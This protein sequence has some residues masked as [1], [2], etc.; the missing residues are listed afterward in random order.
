MKCNPVCA[1]LLVALL[2]SGGPALAQRAVVPLDSAERQALQ[3][4]PRLRQSAQQIEEQ[5]ALKR[6][7]FSP[8]NPDFLFSMPT[9]AR[10]APGLVQT[11]DFPTV[12]R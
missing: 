12:Y 11:V 5:R 3:R 10:W 8:A 7:S 4:H 2:A 1:G 6:G 9:G